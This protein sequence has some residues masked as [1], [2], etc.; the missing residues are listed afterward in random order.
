MKYSSK[1]TILVGFAFFSICAFWQLY[2]YAVPLILKYTFSIGDA[3]SGWVMA[4]DNILAL[5]L[6]PL[7]GSLSDRTSTRIGRRMPFILAGTAM[8]VVLMLFLPFFDRT[9]NFIG[10]FIA[11]GLL[12]IAMGTY[13]SPAVALMPDVTPK[14]F[15]S[16]ANA[17]INLMGAFG[18]IAALILYTLLVHADETGRADYGPIFLSVAGLM[19]LSVLLLFFLVNENKLRQQMP[20]EPQQD[21]VSGQ[22]LPSAVRRS[23]LLILSSVFLW[24]MGYNAVETSYSKY[25]AE[26]LGPDN[27]AAILMTIAMLGAIVSYIPIGILS[28]KVGR[29]PVILAGVCVLTTCFSLGSVVTALEGWVY[30]GFAL[31]GCAWAAINVNSY[32]MVVEISK[33]G[34]VGKYTGYYYAFSMA[35]QIITPVISGWLLEHVGYHT[36]FPYAA[37]MAGCAFFTMFFVKHGD[38]RPE[39][40]KNVLEHFDMEDAL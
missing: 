33:T 20:P 28:T 3:A 22:K 34:D 37:I 8:S 32:P 23:L 6:L 5:F 40:P 15:R 26:M 30:A 18:G 24:Y 14:P 4:M 13:R 39:T 25:F 7:F 12:L 11:L 21:S 31:I 2:N 27:G 17:I 35:A 1:N 38:S 10:F 9:Q 29:K 19:V 16:K 36:L